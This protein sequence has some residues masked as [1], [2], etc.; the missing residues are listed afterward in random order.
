MR[1]RPGIPLVYLLA[2]GVAMSVLALGLFGLFGQP[3]GGLRLL[4]QP[5]VAWSLVAIGA[6]VGAGAIWGILLHLRQNAPR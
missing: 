3:E 1:N 2:D 6:V 4:A 5:A